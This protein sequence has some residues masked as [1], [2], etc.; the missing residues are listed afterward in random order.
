MILV[1]L[2]FFFYLMFC[3]L[4]VSYTFHAWNTFSIY[5]VNGFF[6]FIFLFF[7]SF[8]VNVLCTVNILFFRFLLV[9][10]TF[11]GYFFELFFIIL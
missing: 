9:S 6:L 11:F 3:F 10:S 8:W 7:L 1:Y 4:S 2:F 5:F